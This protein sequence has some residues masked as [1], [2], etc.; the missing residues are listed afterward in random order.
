[1]SLETFDA[2]EACF[3]LQKQN[4]AV[5]FRDESNRP[6]DTTYA[7]YL[8]RNGV[9]VAHR[10]YE[11]S[12]EATFENDGI[13]GRY[14]VKVFVKQ[15]HMHDGSSTTHTF[16]SETIT[17]NGRPYDLRQWNHVPLFERNIADLWG[18]EEPSNGLYHFKI[19]DHHVDL[20]L[21]GMEKVGTS[22]AILVCFNGAVSSRSGM[23]APFFSGVGIAKQL[24]VP[25][26]SVADPTLS[27]SHEIGLGWYA[28]HDGLPDL[29]HYI[30]QLLDSF[31]QRTGSRLILFGG[32]GG[33]FASLLTLGLIKSAGASAFVWNPQTSISQY[34]STFVVCYLKTAFPNHA[35]SNRLDNALESAGIIHD[36]TTFAPLLKSSHQVLY[37][38]NKSDWHTR[39][40]ASPFLAKFPS[41]Q[42]KSEDVILCSENLAYWEGNWGEGHAPPPK[43]II[44]SALRQLLAGKPVATVALALSEEYAQASR[45]ATEE[46]TNT[47]NQ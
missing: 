44:V 31:A 39:T 1:M 35:V 16:D 45:V 5:R 42:E 26:L 20:L 46:D 11:K 29:P 13:A 2:P 19:A 47:A 43:P 22:P 15:M 4:W 30:S 28:G 25:V 24:D 33:G 21:D 10:W 27:W 18:T 12:S 34:N 41:R 32:S 40:H 8:L 17:Q 38:Q 23:S 3:T 6:E 9:R 37:I 14:Q 7:F 36:L